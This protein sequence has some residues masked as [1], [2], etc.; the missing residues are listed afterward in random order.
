MALQQSRKR[1]LNNTFPLFSSTAIARNVLQDVIS[2]LLFM[3]VQ[4]FISSV[5]L[6][7]RIKS[8]SWVNVTLRSGRTPFRRL[9][10]TK[11]YG[12]KILPLQLLYSLQTACLYSHKRS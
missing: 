2:L 4:M 9:P 5:Y 12:L 3:P 1:L 7:S 8:T 6:S 10:F 11:L